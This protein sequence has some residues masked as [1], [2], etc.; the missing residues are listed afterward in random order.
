MTCM[1]T[2]KLATRKLRQDRYETIASIYS[3]CFIYYGCDWGCS[4]AIE[5][6]MTE[7]GYRY[8]VF[9]RIAI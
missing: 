9:C 5:Y 2:I 1:I 3:A 8:I 4:T 6:N 7:T